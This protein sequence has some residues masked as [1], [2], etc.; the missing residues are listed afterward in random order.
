MKRAKGNDGHAKYCSCEVCYR[1]RNLK[2]LRN[3]S[4][5]GINPT[6]VDKYARIEPDSEP[7]DLTLLL[8]PFR[9]FGYALR[10]KEWGEQLLPVSLSRQLN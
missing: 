5:L 7:D 4:L 2:N 6:R 3:K 1:E 10:Y 9:V 8:C